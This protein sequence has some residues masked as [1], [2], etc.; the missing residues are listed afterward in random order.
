MFE[1]LILSTSL[2]DGVYCNIEPNTMEKTL[3][4]D[5]NDNSL[6][7]LHEMQDVKLDINAYKV[8]GRFPLLT[9][10]VENGTAWKNC[11]AP[12]CSYNFI[13][14]NNIAKC[15]L[16]TYKHISLQQYTQIYYELV[17]KEIQ[18]IYE[19]NDN[20]ILQFSGGIDSLTLLSYVIN[21]GYLDRTTL[22]NFENYFLDEHPDLLR[23]NARKN[24]VRSEMIARFKNQCKD[25]VIM[26]LTDD[27]W[28]WASNNLPYTA[29]Q[30]YGS[31]K[32][33]KNYPNSHIITGHH[34]DQVLFHDVMWLNHLIAIA[35]DRDSIITEYNELMVDSSLYMNNFIEFDTTKQMHPIQDFSWHMRCWSE[36]N[37]YNNS[38]FY[39]PL[40]V[41]T[42]LCRSLDFNTVKLLDVLDARIARNFIHMNVGTA[43]DEFITHQG[44]IDGDVFSLKYFNKSNFNE[45]IFT[46]PKNLKHNTAGLVKL[47]QDLREERLG[48]Y[49]IIKLRAL[50]HISNFFQTADL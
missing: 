50:Q 10:L 8:I 3:F 17:K 39:T 14:K 24:T 35:P 31:S 44:N 7:S 45:S 27:D 26:D 40:A 46:I 36:L 5:L 15:E 11:Y 22:I 6:K 42:T 13:V 37:G 21:L 43:L 48:T 28:I 23:N 1:N 9:K 30:L 47:T 25:F 4:V 20:V 18:K 34:G 32:I 2:S 38:Y 29:M 19:N 41:D 49:H 33:Q 16:K 12:S